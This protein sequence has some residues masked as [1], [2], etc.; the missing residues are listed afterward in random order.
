MIFLYNYRIML[1]RFKVNNT[2][3]DKVNKQIPF[4]HQAETITMMMTLLL[5]I[6]EKIG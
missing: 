3:K 4:N 5:I 6:K 1:C 2:I